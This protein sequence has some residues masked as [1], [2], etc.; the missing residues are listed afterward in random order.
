[1][2][3]GYL[4]SKKWD[5]LTAFSLQQSC[6][7]GLKLPNSTRA[8]MLWDIWSNANMRSEYLLSSFVQWRSNQAKIRSY[9]QLISDAKFSWCKI[10]SMLSKIIR[11]VRLRNESFIKHKL[12]CSLSKKR[13]ACYIGWDLVF[14]WGKR[15]SQH[16]LLQACTTKEASSTM[17]S[18]SCSYTVD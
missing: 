1:M 7:I 5:L 3:K 11:T 15:K 12:R 13:D 18:K 2:K 14:S 9:V 16:N 4:W 10:C 6:S 8:S 17:L